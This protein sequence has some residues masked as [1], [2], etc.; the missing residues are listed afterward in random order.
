MAFSSFVLQSI[1]IVFVDEL[2]L[3]VP[4]LSVNATS[5]PSIVIVIFV[6]ELRISFLLTFIL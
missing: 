4:F 5:S 3:K 2:T 1:S 6:S